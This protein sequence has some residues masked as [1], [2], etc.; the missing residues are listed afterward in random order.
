MKHRMIVRRTLFDFRYSGPGSLQLESVTFLTE[1]MMERR[2]DL[3]LVRSGE[4]IQFFV[5]SAIPVSRLSRE[6]YCFVAA[7]ARFLGCLPDQR[8]LPVWL[9]ADSLQMRHSN[10]LLPAWSETGTVREPA[11]C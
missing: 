7:A 10:P 8:N 6:Q 9:W 11:H 1:A 2:N 5:S 4:E 3:L